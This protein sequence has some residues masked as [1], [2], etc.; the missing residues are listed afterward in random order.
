MAVDKEAFKQKAPFGLRTVALFELVKGMLVLVVGM[1]L[2]FLMHTDVQ[3]AAER[4]VDHLHADPAW[5]VTHEFIKAASA[6]TDH[7]IVLVAIFSLIYASIRVVE[8]YGLWH[9]RHWAEWF[10][11]ISAAIY[12]PLEVYHICT[13]PRL[14]GF[15]IFLG[16]VAIVIYLT[17][18]LA[19]RHYEKKIQRLVRQSQ[20][21]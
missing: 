9:E 6:M 11:V 19:A 1:A 13:H 12:L 17:R 7:R 15:T 14:L 16:N 20:A 21:A 2:L 8:S 4:L 10:A 5:A 18:L 3:G